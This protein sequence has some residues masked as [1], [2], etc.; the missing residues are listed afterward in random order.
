MS[1]KF[2]HRKAGGFVYLLLQVLLML[3]VVSCA[4]FSTSIPKGKIF[5]K[6]IQMEIAGVKGRGMIVIPRRVNY[7]L[8]VRQDVRAEH[9]KIASCHMDDV[10][11]K[12]GFFNRKKHVFKLKPF[13]ELE[14]DSFCPIR[15][16]F[17]DLQGQHAWGFI[18]IQN[19]ELPSTIV[20]NL[21]PPTKF[22]GVSVCQAQSGS[23]QRLIFDTFV[24]FTQDDSAGTCG[25]IFSNDNKIFDYFIGDSLCVYNFYDKLS[26]TF[27]RH[28]SFGYNDVI[29]KNMKPLM[30]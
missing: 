14:L 19:E 8:V 11:E 10:Q 3:N 5:K 18:E 28:T 16:G 9:I 1:I 23:I 6:T 29:L 2:L 4:T 24:N 17:F 26:E 7:E 22:K 25:E 20:C 12:S 30:E 21:I 13:D 27:H 15:L